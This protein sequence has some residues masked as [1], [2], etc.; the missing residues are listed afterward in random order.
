MQL[1]TK[2]AAL[3]VLVADP[4]AD[5]GLDILRGIA[6]VDV[7]PGLKLDE[8]ITIIG[9]Y[10]A[11]IVRSQTQ[12]TADV[13][14]AGKKLQVIGRAGVGIDNIDLNAATRRGIVVVNAPTG[15]TVSAAEH[16]IALM[17][18]LARHIPQA[19]AALKNG[20]WQRNKFMGTEVKNKTLGVIGLGNVGAE[21]ARRARGLEMRVIG[22]DPFVSVERAAS[23]QVKLVPLKQLLKES[24]FITLHLPLTQQTRGIIGTKELALVKPTVR[25]INCAR[26]GLID[27]EI[28]ARAVAEQKIAGAAVDVFAEEPTTESALFSED[29]VIVT[30]HLGASTT[31][32][33]AMAARDVAEQVIALFN[34]E[35][36]QYAV[37]LPFAS[38]ETMMVLSPY[39]EAASKGGN[40]MHQLIEGQ[41]SRI[42]IKYEGEITNY[43]TNALKASVLEGLL[44]GVS[45]ERVNMVNAN[46]VAAR[47]GIT[48]VEE[49]E[50][51]CRN[52]ASLITLEATTSSGVTTVAVT[53]M[54]DE[55]HIV[56]VDNYW[57]DIV[58]YGGY[59]LFS[60]HLDR[61]GLLGAVGRITG[62][63]DINISY[64]YVS[65]LKQRGQALMIIALDE[66]LPEEQRQ[67]MLALPDIHTVKVVRL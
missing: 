17:L 15:N 38:A 1:R 62:D 7:R 26:G 45:E 24:D 19:N 43:D 40:L 13:I 55:P 32:A 59:F 4:I 46:L 47:R 60:D 63:A 39:M 49:K 25:I 22:Q 21:V 44:G 27:E 41:M 48:V 51:L 11:L 67:Q 64:M 36:A 58:P 65:R 6:E 3:K 35:P 37:N 5:E 57:T 8:L 10:D 20:V 18:A 52:Y 61:P 56:R 54:R 33:Q 50:S 2:D 14:A 29:E 28:L 42:R 31:E 66:P 30:P 53:V 23:L 9:D 34:G 16:T 12:V